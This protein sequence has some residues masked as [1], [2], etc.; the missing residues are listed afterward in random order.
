M[1]SQLRDRPIHGQLSAIYSIG[2]H[3]ASAGPVMHRRWNLALFVTAIV[4]VLAGVVTLPAM[5]QDAA[6]TITDSADRQVDVP[7]KISRFLAAGPPASILLYTLAPEQ[8][9]GWVRAPNSA[10]KRF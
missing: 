4:G 3:E 5:A 7:G 9:I 6:R 8:M 10:E 1:H 2:Y